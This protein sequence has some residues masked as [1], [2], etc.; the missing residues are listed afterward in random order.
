MDKGS[1]F[2]N[3]PMK[4]WLEENNLKIYSTANEGKTS[5]LLED[6]LKLIKIK[7]INIWFQYLNKCVH[8]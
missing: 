2:Y 5:L 8:W 3:R 7:Y 4:S 6:L 1:G